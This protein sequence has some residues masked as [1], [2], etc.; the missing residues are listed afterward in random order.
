VPSQSF[1]WHENRNAGDYAA[2]TNTP[3]S[4]VIAFAGTN[5]PAMADGE[6]IASAI[7]T[8][9]HSNYIAAGSQVVAQQA[10]QP[11]IDFEAD[12]TANVILL[13]KSDAATAVGDV[14]CLQ[15]A[16]SGLTVSSITQTKTPCF[17]IVAPSAGF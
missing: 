2:M 5:A 15:P 13:I 8:D 10:S 14:F 12:S 9:P 1:E 16:L 3:S 17:E 7:L 6:A 4:T 11:T